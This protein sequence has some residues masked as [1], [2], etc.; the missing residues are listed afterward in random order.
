[1]STR[2]IAG[3]ALALGLAL[4]SVAYGA[5]NTAAPAQPK[6][7][8]HMTKKHVK[9]VAHGSAEVRMLQTA[10]NKHGAK[11]MVDGRMGKHTHAALRAFQKKSGLKVTGT[12]DKATRAK[13][14]L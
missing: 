3:L 12:L 4:G 9:K 6:P 1:M 2:V 7:A 10:L 14:G 8:K 5:T 13:L 11:L